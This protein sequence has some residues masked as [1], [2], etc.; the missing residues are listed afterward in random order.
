MSPDEII[1]MSIFFGS[2]VAVIFIITVGSIVKAWLKKNSSKSL[3]EN[4]EFLDALRE[5]KENMER[6]MSNLEEIVSEERSASSISTKIEKKNTQRAIELEFDDE[7]REERKA[8]ETAK[9]R[10][11]LNQ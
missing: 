4:Q 7:S 2:I 10:N 5:F 1:G 11:M 6:R 8:E 9:L 3:S